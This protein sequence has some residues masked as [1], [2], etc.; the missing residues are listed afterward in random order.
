MLQMEQVM[1]KW[2]SAQMITNIATFNTSF[3][4]AQHNILRE[5]HPNFYKVYICWLLLF[6]W[7]WNNMLVKFLALLE[8]RF[9]IS[10]FLEKVCSFHV[11]PHDS[12]VFQLC[13]TYKT[14]KLLSPMCFLVISQT[15]ACKEPMLA[16]I[17]IKWKHFSFFVIFI[18]VLLIYWCISQ[19]LSAY[20]TSVCYVCSSW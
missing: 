20:R 10:T 1:E 3:P 14:C 8:V 19:R 9:T 16:F 13:I 7:T 11:S 4:K 18:H 5:W 15:T 12:L 6:S 17:T 2:K